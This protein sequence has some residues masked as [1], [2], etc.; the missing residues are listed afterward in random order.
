MTGIVHGCGFAAM[1]SKSAGYS[2]GSSV[3]QPCSQQ[4]ATKLMHG[5]QLTFFACPEHRVSE[6]LDYEPIQNRVY[7][8]RQRMKKEGKKKLYGWVWTVSAHFLLCLSMSCSYLSASTS[9]KSMG[10][11][12]EELHGSAGKEGWRGP[13][14]R[15]VV[16]PGI[17]SNNSHS[18]HQ[19]SLCLTATSR[20]YG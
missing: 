12:S 11:L 13:N 19:D 1:W 9:S 18:S 14:L 7:Q 16:K 20:H 17:V 5:P 2:L 10:E 15:L 3:Q 8:D 6:S 4:H